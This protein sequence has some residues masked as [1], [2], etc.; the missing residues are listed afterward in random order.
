[1]DAD[2]LEVVEASQAAQ[3]HEK[4]CSF[5]A[6][7]ETTVWLLPKSSLFTDRENHNSINIIIRLESEGSN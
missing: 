2:D 1:M 6:Q 5:P 7:Y 4:I 3:I